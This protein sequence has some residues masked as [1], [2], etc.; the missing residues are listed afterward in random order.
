[1]IA[2]A[3]DD[4]NVWTYPCEIVSTLAPVVCDSQDHFDIGLVCCCYDLI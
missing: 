2:V 3:D 4:G 1:M